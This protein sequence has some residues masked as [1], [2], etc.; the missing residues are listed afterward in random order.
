M[1]RSG[2]GIEWLILKYI[3]NIKIHLQIKML[4]LNCK[5]YLQNSILWRSIKFIKLVFHILN[6]VY[7]NVVCKESSMYKSGFR[8]INKLQN[9]TCCPVYFTSSTITKTTHV[10]LCTLLRR[11]SQN[12]ICC[13]VYFTSSTIS[14]KISRYRLINCRK[15][16][17]VIQ[18][19]IAQNSTEV[20]LK[21]T[22]F[23]NHCESWS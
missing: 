12:N 22:N 21:T 11:Q 20:I 5:S 8:I 13:H 6:F 23:N 4:A 3:C 10:V 14:I 18:Y 16:N 7:W 1:V 2:G 9:N 15:V 17:I 19:F